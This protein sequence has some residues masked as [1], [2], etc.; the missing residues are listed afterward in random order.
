MSKKSSHEFSIIGIP[1]L[2]KFETTL[3]VLS[4]DPVATRSPKGLLKAKE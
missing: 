1:Y 4:K 3:A 2:N